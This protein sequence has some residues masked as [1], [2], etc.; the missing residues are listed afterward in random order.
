M[1]TSN[2]WR[3]PFL[4][5]FAIVGIPTEYRSSYRSFIIK[6]SKLTHYKLLKNYFL[7][8][9][10]SIIHT[11]SIVGRHFGTRLVQPLTT[12]RNTVVRLSGHVSP[13]LSAMAWKDSNEHRSF[14]VRSTWNINNDHNNDYSILHGGAWASHKQKN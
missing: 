1:M 14:S 2:I 3:Q 9:N 6:I 12:S 7:C 8:K 11:S 5:G 4:K 10:C 13:F